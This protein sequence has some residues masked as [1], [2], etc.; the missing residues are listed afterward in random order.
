MNHRFPPALL[1]PVLVALSLPLLAGGPGPDPE[2]RATVDDAP[3]AADDAIADASFDHSYKVWDA[4]LRAHV[5]RSG[6]VDYAALRSSAEL[7]SFL[8]SVANVA[9]EEVGG[10]SRSQKIAFYSNAYNALTFQTILDAWP[11]ASIRDIKPDPWEHARWTVAGRTMSLNQVEHS[12]LRGD[13]GEAR[14]HFV[15]V[16]AAKSCPVLPNRA[17][18]PE[19]ISGQLERYAK[20]FFTDSAR[21]RVD[22]AGGKVYLSRIL[23]WYGGDFVGKQAPELGGVASL[24]E[25]EAAAIRYMAK[26]LDEDTVR[27]LDTGEYTVV[28]NEYDWS[29]NKQ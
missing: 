23:D 24:S 27:F 28:F 13:L 7:K 15:L 2:P 5:D 16:C 18:V 9:P 14:V 21:N 17:L 19:N 10:W 26:Y 20:A 3:A 12:K 11:V 6:N 4:I 8:D 25:K 22:V 1:L 29:L